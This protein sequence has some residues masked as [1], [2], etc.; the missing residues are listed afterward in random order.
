M[1]RIAAAVATWTKACAR[2]D[3]PAALLALFLLAVSPGALLSG[4]AVHAAQGLSAG[5][6]VLNVPGW[7]N[8]AYTLP[9]PAN[10][11]DASPVVIAIHAA[12]GMLRAWRR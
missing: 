5:D 7:S 10:Y 11:T 8:R 3:G 6:Y 2:R 9:L 4:T 1:N 12:G